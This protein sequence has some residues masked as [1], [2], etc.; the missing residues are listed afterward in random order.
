MKKIRFAVGCLL[1]CA[2]LSC[3]SNDERNRI[4]SAGDMG[5]KHAAEVIGHKTDTLKMQY[6]LLEARSREQL[7][8]DYNYNEA[9]D[10]YIM[11]FEE[12]IKANDDSLARL[13]L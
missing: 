10:A 4:L 1:L 7:L 2:T 11:A 12:Y 3:S 9:A 6:L 13:I 5:R 8:R